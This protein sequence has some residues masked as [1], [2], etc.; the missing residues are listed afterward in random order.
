M[1][2]S[3][4]N[5]TSSL[6]ALASHSTL[7]REWQLSALF[8]QDMERFRRFSLEAAGLFL[9]YSKNHIDATTV[10]LL[11]GLARSCGLEQR[12]D[13]MFKGE[14]VNTTEQRPALHTLLRAPAEQRFEL[15][16][17]VLSSEVQQVLVRMDQLS[18]RVRS[19]EWLGFTGKVITDVVNIGIGGS[20][21]G[22]AMACAALR[23]FIKPGLRAHFLSNVDGHAI[24]AVLSNL[25]PETTLFIIASKSFTTQETLINAHV[26]R[27]WFLNKGKASDLAK[28]FVAVSTNAKAVA[29]FG[30][31][32]ANMLPFW[33]WVGGRYSVWSAIGLSV[34]IAVG[35]DNFRAFLA[36]AHMMDRHFQESPLEQNMPV[37]LGLI[38]WWYRQHFGSTSHLVA[39]YHEDLRLFP[40]HLQQ[41]DMESNGKRVTTAGIPVTSPTAQVIWG[42]TGTNG[43]HAYFQMLHQGTDVVPVDFIAAIHPSHDRTNQHNA[44]LANCFAQA[45]ALMV[46]HQKDERPGHVGEALAEFRV[47]PGN[48]PSNTLLIDKLTP[49]SLGTLLALYEHKTFVQGV[50]WDINS[51]DQWGVERGKTLAARILPELEGR[52]SS[53]THDGSTVGLIN[54]TLQKKH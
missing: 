46:G 47:L 42:S 3:Q 21:L 37:I 8:A 7:A 4:S 39:P 29:E 53:H 26:A 43:Q 13:A 1:S 19:G 45:E 32:T 28:H 6:A 35:M 24:D 18:Q 9:D 5:K 38:S 34:A 17:E 54:R 14:S 27:E 12:R 10:S 44:L 40:L 41:V 22:P 20:D 48:R 33:D 11:A 16:G 15:D 2:D 51:F 23:P 52:T 25:S 30:I 36:G 50:L 49:T 31:D